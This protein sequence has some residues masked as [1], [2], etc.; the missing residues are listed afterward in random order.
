MDCR[1]SLNRVYE[2]G[3]TE[4]IFTPY[5][6]DGRVYRIATGLD[7]FLDE[8]NVLSFDVNYT[9]D[10]HDFFNNSAYSHTCIAAICCSNTF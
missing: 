8:K 9:E 4:N 3:S 1:Q 7:V 2:D 10:T 6:F 5:N